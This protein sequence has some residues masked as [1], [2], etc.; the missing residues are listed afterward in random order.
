V[1]LLDAGGFQV[2]EDHLNEVRRF[3]REVFAGERVDE[4]IVFIDSQGAVRR[5]AFDGEGSGYSDFFVVFVGLVVEVFVFGFGGDGGV[6]FFLTGDAEFPP[7]GVE[8][9][10]F[11]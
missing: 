4:V 8:L 9:S 1:G 11:G 5:E 3:G 2:F 10:G 6:D 7:V